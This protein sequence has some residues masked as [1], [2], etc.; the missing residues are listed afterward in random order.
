MAAELILRPYQE[1]GVNWLVSG[2]AHKLLADDMGLGKTPQA[3]EAMNRLQVR[4]ALIICPSTVK[5][6]WARRLM[7]WSK[8]MRHVFIV[9]DGKASIPADAQA[10]V[11]NYELVLRNKINRQLQARGANQGYDLLLCDESR[12]LKNQTAKRTKAI[13][14]KSSFTRHAKHK[15]LLDGT[16]VPNRP[17]ELF[18]VLSALAPDV[19]DPYLTWQLFGEYFCRGKKNIFGWDMS[20][21]SNIEELQN[22][23][24]GSGFMLRRT[25]E[26]VMD[27]LPNKVETLVG[28]DVSCAAQLDDSHIATVRREL[29][30][31]KLPRAV[32]HIASLLVNVDKVVVFAHHR[33]VIEQLQVA[34]S[35]H[36]AVIVYGGMTADQKQRSID[37]FVSDP[38][39]QVL[40]GQTVAGGTGVDGLQTVCNH[41]VFVELDWSPGVMDQAIDRCRR[42]GQE[43][44]T[45]FVQYLA[46]PD[47]LD[48][49][50]ENTLDKKRRVIEKLIKSNGKETAMSLEATLE[51]MASDTLAPLLERIAVA[52]EKTVAGP[53]SVPAAPAPEPAKAAPAKAKAEPA[54]PAAPTPAP[55]PA[56]PAAPAIDEAALRKAATEFVNGS[57]DNQRMVRDIIL[58]RYDGANLVGD[59]KPE[60]YESFAADLAKGV[61]YW[62]A[63]APKA[64]DLLEV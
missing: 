15:W 18:P 4:S 11:V 56:K 9:R 5:I 12:Y 48:T 14:G 26:E 20:G 64:D 50:M 31:A 13:L 51:K 60:Y 43:H 10:I 39:T 23:L 45:V 17:V 57:K 55:E 33:D 37:A 8:T 47:S 44:D 7:Q 38:N 35:N 36:G 41:I 34:L 3:I 32:E 1:A 40:I 30:L 24:L 6:M 19:I 63:H 21:H 27:E 58:P 53:A 62:K 42:I 22:R 29:A 49:V 2:R 28:L 52:L 25:K 59:L 46:V 54:K 61:D 16:P